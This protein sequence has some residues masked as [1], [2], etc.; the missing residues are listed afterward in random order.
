MP[1]YCPLSVTCRQDPAPLDEDLSKVVGVSDQTPPASYN[2]LLVASSGHS[3]QVGH[4]GVAW[5]LGKL[6]PLRFT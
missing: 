2:E 3:L 1:S 6:T 4:R 5:V